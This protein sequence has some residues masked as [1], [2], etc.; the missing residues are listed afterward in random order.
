MQVDIG[1]RRLSRP[2]KELK[3]AGRQVEVKLLPATPHVQLN[4]SRNSRSW[5]AFWKL[6]LSTRCVRLQL[7]CMGM[8]KMG[9]MALCCACA[10]IVKF[11][12]CITY[13]HVCM[14]SIHL[15]PRS[16]LT[17]LYHDKQPHLKPLSFIPAQ[18]RCLE[19][20]P[21]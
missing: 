9:K 10:A 8:S 6:G 11:H 20:D 4:A 18:N 3:A 15:A 16:R 7:S 19:T 17:H 12:L 5:Q 2:P 14:Y 13:I 21:K 1:T